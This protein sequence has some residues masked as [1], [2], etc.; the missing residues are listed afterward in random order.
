MA[1]RFDSLSPVLRAGAFKGPQAVCHK[2]AKS[3]LSFDPSLRKASVI[4][5][6]LPKALPKWVLLPRRLSRGMLT[7]CVPSA[8]THGDNWEEAPLLGLSLF[9]NNSLEAGSKIF[10]DTVNP[11]GSIPVNAKHQ[12]LSFLL[13]DCVTCCYFIGFFR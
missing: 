12:T 7:R 9:A 8:G 5:L 3:R 10:H 1:A 11:S 4:D 2:P 13:T 6:L